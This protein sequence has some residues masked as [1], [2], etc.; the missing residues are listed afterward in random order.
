MLSAVT[1]GFA[2]VGFSSGNCMVLCGRKMV[3]EDER[4]GV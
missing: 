4:E 2:W 1:S 3:S